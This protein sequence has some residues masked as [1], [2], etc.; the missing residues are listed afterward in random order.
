MPRLI[1]LFLC[2][3]TILLFS[4]KSSASSALV[5]V[6][7]SPGAPP[8]L[9]FN[10]VKNAYQGLV[11]DFFK[12]LENQQIL[13]A[14]FIDSSRKRSERFIIAGK[15]DMMLNS[16]DW[17][18]NPD[19]LISSVPILKFKSYLYSLTPF[20]EDF[21]L[22]SIKNSKICARWGFVYPGL[23]QYFE[24]NSLVRVDSSGQ[25]NMAMMLLKNRCDYVVMNNHNAAAIFANKA[26]C[27]TTI[28]QSPITTNEVDLV[29]I[30]RPDMP[31]VHSLVNQQI[32]QFISNG[33][34]QE[35][36]RNHSSLMK[37]PSRLS[38]HMG[39]SKS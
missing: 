23:N 7:N 20:P 5:F 15:A 32:E 10:K 25:P 11:V 38:C 19:K 9:Y 31:E 4:Q 1:C 28:Y 35:S 39:S 27:N 24:N 8:Y 6:V 14:K 29:L 37:F 33:K 21:S 34:M 17:L 12:E 13:K 18:D 16:P 3:A 26:F 22:D 36:L 2:L 30:M